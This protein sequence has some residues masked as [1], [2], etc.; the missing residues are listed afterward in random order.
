MRFP[1]YFDQEGVHV[2]RALQ[3]F[4]GRASKSVTGLPY[5]FLES[6]EMLSPGIELSGG[7]VKFS[8]MEKERSRRI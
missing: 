7:S 6:M 4:I 2:G 3:L 1:L 5:W 8:V